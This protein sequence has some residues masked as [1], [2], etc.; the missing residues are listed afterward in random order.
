MT[1]SKTKKLL[2]TLSMS[3]SPDAQEENSTLHVSM[4]R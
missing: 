3:P 1:Q 2:S 4:V